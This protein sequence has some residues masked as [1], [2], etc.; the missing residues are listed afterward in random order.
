MTRDQEVGVVLW[1]IDL[2]SARVGSA[3]AMEIRRLAQREVAVVDVALDR[4]VT[5]GWAER[6]VVAEPGYRAGTRVGDGTYRLTELGIQR[7]R[8]RT[9]LTSAEAQR[10]DDLGLTVSLTG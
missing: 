5:W 2:V 8:S 6:T 4:A 9:D 10:S 7:Q 1:A 3:T